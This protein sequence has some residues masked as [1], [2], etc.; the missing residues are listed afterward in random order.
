M[1]VTLFIETYVRE[2]MIRLYGFATALERE[3]FRLLQ[4]NVQGVGAKVALAILST[5][6]PP[7]LANAIALRD[8]AMVSRAPGVGKKVAER[9]VTE[10]KNKAPG[11]RR[12]GVRHNRAEA[13]DRR[14]RRAG[15]HHR[16]GLGADQSRLFT[17]RGGQRGCRGAEGGGRGR[18]FGEAD[19]AR[20]EGIG[21][22][23]LEN[24]IFPTIVV[25]SEGMKKWGKFSQCRPKGR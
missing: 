18:R 24:E 12:I 23:A 20:A 10:L 6:S 22:V 17:R 14:R 13:G 7:D 4:S 15:A 16:R 1:A 3:W 11:L 2:D 25:L 9:I 8:I 5:L 19:P 21:T